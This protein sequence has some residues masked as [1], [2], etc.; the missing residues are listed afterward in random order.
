MGTS[1]WHRSPE[2]EQWKR[3]RE[4]Y[5]QPNPSPVEVA[6]RIAGALDAQ[7]HAGMQG[8]AVATCL[9]ALV[10][11][12]AAIERDGLERTL[13]QMGLPPEPAAV[14]LAA[15]LRDRAEELI[16]QTGQASRFG[17]LALEAV[18]TTALAL[19]TLSD[20][21]AGLLEVPLAAVEVRFRSLRTEGELHRMAALYT[22]H[23]LDRAFR[24]FVA[25][26]VGDFVGGEGLPTVSDANRL[27]DAVAAHCRQTW[28]RLALGEY[29]PI[30]AE[31]HLLDPGERFEVLQPVVASGI[32][33]GLEQIAAGVAG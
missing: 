14:Q 25:R 2:T 22:G 19:A 16:A 15:G 29:E 5:A 18:G 9:G 24:Y 6:R 23:D 17:D 13:Q 3:V 11:G 1:T 32:E 33:Q 7:T 26:D 30:L 21:G 10:E 27:E 12:C 4:L 20:S 31:A 8:P 28:R